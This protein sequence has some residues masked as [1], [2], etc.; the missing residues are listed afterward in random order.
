MIRQVVSENGADE[1]GDGTIVA[2]RKM[3]LQCY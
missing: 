2:I 1:A 3:P